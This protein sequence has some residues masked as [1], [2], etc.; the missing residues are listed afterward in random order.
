MFRFAHL[1]GF[2]GALQNMPRPRPG[3]LKRLSIVSGYDQLNI[4]HEE[5]K[6][7]DYSISEIINTGDQ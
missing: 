5:Q 7:S 3:S 2:R 4:I 1:F 6:G